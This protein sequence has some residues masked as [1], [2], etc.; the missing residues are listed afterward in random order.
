V[1]LTPRAV[2]PPAARAATAR[3]MR[4]PAGSAARYAGAAAG[5]LAALAATLALAPQISRANFILFSVAVPFA[6]WYAG[7][8]VGV[9]LAA[10]SV[11]AIDF[12]LV[13]PLYLLGPATRGMVVTFAVLST[14]AAVVGAL[15]RAAD[16]ARR[17]ADEH[18][19]L[20]QDQALEL[21]QQA[22]EAQ[23]LVDELARANQDL[24]AVTLHAEASRDQAQADRARLQR[25]FDS[26]PDA[27]AVFDAESRFTYLNPVAME[28]LRAMG[29]DPA[30]L[31]GRSIWDEF[32]RLRAAPLHR[33]VASALREERAVAVEHRSEDDARWFETRVVP[34]GDGAVT[35]SR[36]VT[37]RRQ[38]DARLR[39]D[40]AR[41]RHLFVANPLPMWV[42]DAATSAVLDVNEAAQRSYGYSRERFLRL[43]P[44]DLAASPGPAEADGASPA[45]ATVHRTSDGTRLEVELSTRRIDFEGRPAL[46][47]LA[48]DVTERRRAAAREH[49]LA[50][51]SE[52]LASSLDREGTLAHVAQLAVPTLAD[53]CSVELVGSDGAVELLAVAHVDPA[54]VEYAREL[55]R[56]YP[57][58][59]DSATGV[60]AVLRTGRSEF[61]PHVPDEAL[62]ASARDPEH[63]AI[64]REIGFRSVIMSPLSSNGRTVGVLTLVTAESGRRFVEADVGVA[65][66]LGRRAALAL[67]NAR[68]YAAEQSA[69]LSAEAAVARTERLQAVTAALSATL[70]PTQVAHAVVEHG[71]AAVGARAGAVA[72]LDES[73]TALVLLDSVGY[74]AEAV[75]RYRRM[76]LDMDFPLTE[77]ARLGESIILH[78]TEE[79][80]A[81]Y[82]HLGELRRA[83]GAGPMMTV[84]L[85]IEGRRVGVLGINFPH[86]VA[87]GDED[88]RFVLA[89]AQQCAQALDR[90][91]LY[92]LEQTA[93]RSAERLQALT[94]ALAE[95]TTPAAVGAV[96]LAQGVRALGAR[97]GVVA[98]R[99]AAGDALE[100]VASTGYPPE[101]CMGPGR[102]WPADATIPI[103]DATRRGEPVLVES[104]AA[105]RER[106]PGGYTPPRTGDAA[107]A[108]LPVGAAAGDDAGAAGAAGALLWTFDGSRHFANADRALM[109]TV[110]RLCTQ[111]LER[112][113]LFEAER[114]ARQEAQA[115]NRIKSDFLATM[116]HEL[117]TP[118]NAIGGYAELLEMGIRGPVT[119]QQRTDLA[120]IQ[121]SQRHL[122]AL[123][124]DVLNFVRLDAGQVHYEIADVPVAELLADVAALVSPQLA[125]KELRFTTQADA[126]PL[127]VR[128]DRDKVAQILLNLL[129]N[130][131]K[132]TPPGGSVTLA[133]APGDGAAGPVVRLSVADTGLGIAPDYLESIFEPFVQVQ[134][135]LTRT[136][137]GTGL[138][139]AISRDLA[140]AMQGDLRVDTT[141]GAGSTFTLTLPAG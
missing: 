76:S 11:L 85:A 47:T 23:V 81:R 79:R 105:W 106:Y 32:P 134:R 132:F 77:A 109:D 1:R 34:M 83:N 62:A 67:D 21:E 80:E 22:E 119:D 94:A 6:A 125:A 84:P 75:E 18:A 71:V 68:L 118:L 12:F 93:R 29:R 88:R 133:C 115:A 39:D 140:Q 9:A 135:G 52:L 103:A 54:R 13:P 73:G 128:G 113:R 95:A 129:S 35:Y 130:A 112:A 51:A 53:W 43:T 16:A 37:S 66:E 116:S 50:H 5:W 138:G 97:A 87:I 64:L 101:A 28:V 121:R 108:A 40:E 110:A 30:A 78:T 98:L 24:E 100:V 60:A 111:A 45:G 139:L 26:L 72:V 70:T 44:A 36:D 41:F 48:V 69:R 33:E 56:R 4:R 57:R 58:P 114:A 96:V 7:A 127:V 46:L 19:M 20:L 104:M 131:I 92:D 107:W 91:R 117:R 63:L 42:V 8:A 17:H 55:R 61:Y 25:L 49:F 86:T 122:L 59:A 15:T 74:P 31:I 136:S 2:V 90:A 99:T 124:N 120:R 137:E 3:W 89:L 141:L 27:T 82:P 38:A 126:G 10:A 102:R 14:A 123:V 65:E